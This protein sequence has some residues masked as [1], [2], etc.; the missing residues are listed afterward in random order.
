MHQLVV[1][2]FQHCLMHGVTMKCTCILHSHSLITCSLLGT[3]MPL[4]IL[5][6]NILTPNYFSY[7][8]TKTKSVA[9]TQDCRKNYC[10]VCLTSTFLYYRAHEIIFSELNIS[11]HS[12]NLICSWH[13]LESNFD[14]EVTVFWDMTPY[15]LVI[16]YRRNLLPSFQ[17][18]PATN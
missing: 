18:S 6:H 3:N 10:F 11:K 4:S 9:T 16:S 12:H 5:L 7:G 13:F 1:K 15:W 8:E 17:D 14:F 2:R